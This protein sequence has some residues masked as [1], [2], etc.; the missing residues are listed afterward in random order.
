MRWNSPGSGEHCLQ[1]SIFLTLCPWAVAH[2][3]RSW[4][5]APGLAESAEHNCESPLDV[6]KVKDVSG[7]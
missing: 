5:R 4:L 1:L 2:K 3:Q 6:P 7:K